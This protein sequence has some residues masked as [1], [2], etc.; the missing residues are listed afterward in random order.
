MNH[1]NKMTNKQI[2]DALRCEFASNGNSD[3]CSDCDKTL[4]CYSSTK[5]VSRLIAARLEQ[6]MGRCACVCR[7]D[8]DDDD[9]WRD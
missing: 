3:V 5:E 4:F 8:E 1:I 6:L 9:A 2:I 7:E